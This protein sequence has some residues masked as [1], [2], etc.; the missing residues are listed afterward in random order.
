LPQA[1]EHLRQ[2]LRLRP[3]NSPL[4]ACLGRILEREERWS[5]ALAEYQAELQEDPPCE[6][7]LDGLERV[8][9]RTR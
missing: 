8:Q 9:K 6:R 7:A 4:F 5:D 3:S 1:E 2:A